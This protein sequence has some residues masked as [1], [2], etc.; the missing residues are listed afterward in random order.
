[1]DSNEKKRNIA[2]RAGRILKIAKHMAASMSWQ[3]WSAIEEIRLH[4]EG[5]AE[6]GYDSESDLIATGNWNSIRSYDASTKLTTT[7]SDL[8]QRICNLFEKMGIEC[9]WSDE[10]FDC[11]CGKLVRS[12]GDSYSWTP[13]FAYYDDEITCIDCLLEDPEGYL[14]E[15]EGNSE[16][17]NTIN[18]INPLDH[19]YVQVGSG[20]HRP[21]G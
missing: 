13:S 5:Y 12:Q 10:W 2:K 9:E 3:V 16:I 20:V 8:P 6:P 17:A 21:F 7:I 15:L 1:M 4:S 18:D 14:S 19:G 11:S